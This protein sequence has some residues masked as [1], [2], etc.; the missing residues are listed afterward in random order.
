[1]GTIMRAC[2]RAAS[3]AAQEKRLQSLQM[4]RDKAAAKHASCNSSDVMRSLRA[5]ERELNQRAP[6]GIKHLNIDDTMHRV[7]S[8]SGEIAYLHKELGAEKEAIAK[9]KNKVNSVQQKLEREKE[10]HLEKI[11]DMK[12]KEKAKLL[13]Q[14]ERAE[15]LVRIRDAQFSSAADA[16]L[17][18]STAAAALRRDLDDAKQTT[19]KLQ[20]ELT[21]ALEA[22]EKQRDDAVADTE[23]ERCKVTQLQKRVAGF[24]S[25]QERKRRPSFEPATSTPSTSRSGRSIEPPLS[26]PFEPLKY[27]EPDEKRR[28]YD[29]AEFTQLAN[30]LSSRQLARALGTERIREILRTKEGDAVC[31]EFAEHLRDRL[32]QVWDAN[33]AIE[34]KCIAGCSDHQMD[35]LRKAFSLLPGDS[36]GR[37]RQRTWYTSLYDSK[38]HVFFPSPIRPRAEW[39]KMWTALCEKHDIQSSADGQMSERS[40]GDVFDLVMERNLKMANDGAGRSASW[41]LEGPIGSADAVSWGHKLKVTHGGLKFADFKSGFSA[42][43]EWNYVT[44]M[45]GRMDDGHASQ[46]RLCSTFA[47]DFGK[48]IKQGYRDVAGIGRVYFKGGMCTDMAFTRAALGRRAMSSP[49]CECGKDKETRAIALHEPYTIPRNS[50][51]ENILKAVQGRCKLLTM[52][53]CCEL[54]HT[55]PPDHVWSQPLRCTACPPEADGSAKIVF[56]SKEELEAEVARLAA[57]ERSAAAG[58]ADAKKALKKENDMFAQSHYQFAKYKRPVL[59]LGIDGTMRSWRQDTMHGINL[60]IAKTDF[61]YCWLD[62]AT[63]A[64][65]RSLDCCSA[66]MFVCGMFA[67]AQQTPLLTGWLCVYCTDEM[68]TAIAGICIEFKVAFDCRAPKKSGGQRDDNRKWMKA[69]MVNV[70]LEKMPEMIWKLCDV[71]YLTNAGN[72]EPLPRPNAPASGA[73]AAADANAA[74]QSASSDGAAAPAAAGSAATALPSEVSRQAAVAQ[75]RPGAVRRAPI[76]PQ[77]ATAIRRAPARP[78]AAAAASSASR[79]GMRTPFCPTVYS[80]ASL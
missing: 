14:E 69:S 52:R 8:Q 2:D 74:S 36:G 31:M 20:D 56:K 7:R 19:A 34:M 33:L 62:G 10:V 61:K 21:A 13:S 75:E 54:T 55:A 25:G 23:A 3:L 77:P 39:Y 42:H 79:A 47:S 46:E 66:S 17:A 48:A 53:R 43:S 80:S 15:R 6:L 30:K 51:Y 71:R 78:Q 29:G 28:R 37:A 38:G 24:K 64:R 11:K 32:E 12:E 63:G 67:L 27:N 76:R 26:F 68:R 49:H 70:L 45:V 1:M 50:S 22:M 18:A 16:E 9:L 35:E 59:W 5:A 41:P 72:P 40:F 4:G 58:D 57:L 65:Q 44:A 73:P 60:N